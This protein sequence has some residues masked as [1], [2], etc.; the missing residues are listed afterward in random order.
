MCI[1][2]V[3]SKRASLS[4]SRGYN[5]L[6]HTECRTDWLFDNTALPNKPQANGAHAFSILLYG[7]QMASVCVKRS[8]NFGRV[9][10]KRL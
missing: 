4:G 2:V 7:L 1:K 8:G 9:T 6:S 5:Q 3:C 10:A